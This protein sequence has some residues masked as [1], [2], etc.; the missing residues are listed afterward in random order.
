MPNDGY[1]YAHMPKDSAH[2]EAQVGRPNPSQL[3]TYSHAQ[4][5]RQALAKRWG[6]QNG[7]PSLVGA[8]LLEAA[9]MQAGATTLARQ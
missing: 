4:N 8:S 1:S 3:P 6:C 7:D 9:N 5:F 2:I